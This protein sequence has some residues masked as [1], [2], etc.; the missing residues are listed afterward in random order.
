MIKPMK[1][2]LAS[3]IPI[4]VVGCKSVP[5]SASV[6]MAGPFTKVTFKNESKYDVYYSTGL[7][8]RNSGLFRLSGNGAGSVSSD[9]FFRRPESRAGEPE[10][11]AIFVWEDPPKKNTVEFP[12]LPLTTGYVPSQ[13]AARSEVQAIVKDDGLHVKAGASISVWPWLR[14]PAAPRAKEMAHELSR[15]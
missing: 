5:P 3:A 2:L 8:Y 12:W 1:L 11:Y 4:L 13:V 7:A 6:P 14:K 15:N 10:Y 9:K